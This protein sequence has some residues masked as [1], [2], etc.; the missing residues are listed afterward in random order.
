M[1]I[2]GAFNHTSGEVIRAAM[3]T[4]G[5]P[6]AVVEWTSHMLGNRNLT[7]NKGNITLCGI[8]DLGCPKG[9]VV[10]L[11]LWCKNVNSIIKTIGE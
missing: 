7:T 1:G 9:G 5:V 6:T 2:E 8:V 3:I 10:S 11:L 4:H